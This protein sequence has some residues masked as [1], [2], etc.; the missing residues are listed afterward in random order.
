MTLPME[1]R[2]VNVNGG[3]PGCS[4]CRHEIDHAAMGHKMRQEREACGISQ[5][6]VGRAIGLSSNYISDLEAGR[7]RWTAKMAERYLAALKSIKP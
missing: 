7:R 2:R 6:E 5:A 4:F 3:R 1:K